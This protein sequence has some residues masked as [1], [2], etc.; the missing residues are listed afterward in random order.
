MTTWLFLSET[1]PRQD[2][3]F[4][5]LVVIGAPVELMPILLEAAVFSD[6]GFGI[7]WSSIVK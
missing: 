1:F 7:I 3:K 4:D 6:Y 2:K 5:K